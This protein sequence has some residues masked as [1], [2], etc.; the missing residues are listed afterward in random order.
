MTATTRSA[1][2]TPRSTR[3]ARPDAS[4]T[5]SSGILRT[6]IGSGMRAPPGWCSG[7]DDG[8]G[9]PGGGLGDGVE[10]TDRGADAAGLDEPAGRLDLGSHGPGG[11]AA[12]LGQPAQEG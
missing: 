7:V 10:R 12:V 11:E 2:R 9:P 8:A 4:D 3:S 6:S 1:S 5:P